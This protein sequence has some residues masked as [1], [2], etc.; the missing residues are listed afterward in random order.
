REAMELMGPEGLS[1]G[2]LNDYLPFDTIVRVM[3]DGFEAFARGT[4]LGMIGD[5]NAGM[6]RWRVNVFRNR[7]VREDGLWKIREMRITPIMDAD[8]ASGWGS[9]GTLGAARPPMPAMLAPHPVTGEAIAPAGLEIVA[10]EAL[11][12]AAPQGSRPSTTDL[13]DVRRR[14]LRSEAW[15]GTENVSSAYGHCLDDFQWPCMSGIFAENGNKQSP[16]AGY[17]FGRDRIAGAATAMYGETPDPSTVMRQR[18]AI[19][20]RIA[21]VIHVSHDGRSTLLRTYLFHPNTG[22]Y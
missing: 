8:Y 19:H 10:G 3:P 4:V 20:W 12:G 15:D 5:A 13:A 18:V 22:K 6:A 17:Y 9:G 16:F 1:E 2:I 7:F 21:P 11:T 14:L